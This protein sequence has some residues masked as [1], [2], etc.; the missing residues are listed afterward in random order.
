MPS[1]I[2]LRTGQTGVL[3]TTVSEP[4]AFMKRQERLFIV[5][6][7]G[8]RRPLLLR[9]PE[10]A[11]GQS[12]FSRPST[13][14]QLRRL[15][16][17]VRQGR[18]GGHRRRPD[19]GS[20]SSVPRT[21]AAVA[22]ASRRLLARRW[23]VAVAPESRPDRPWL[24]AL[25]VHDAYRGAPVDVGRAR[26]KASLVRSAALQRTMIRARLRML[27]REVAEHAAI[28]AVAAARG[29]LGPVVLASVSRDL[30]G[31]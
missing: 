9:L 17:S 23:M 11:N 4:E 25:A 1:H 29:H 28:S 27:V 14:E 15:F 8:R 20:G 16:G 21:C 5:P 22:P 26:R 19:R 31:D 3:V 7:R 13:P 18:T 12:A 24:M 30:A 2:Y 6:V 10:H